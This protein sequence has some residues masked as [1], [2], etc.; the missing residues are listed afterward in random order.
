MSVPTT[1]EME[2]PSAVLYLCLSDVGR[3]HGGAA[4][5]GALHTLLPA[6]LSL[7]PVHSPPGPS[8]QAGR[9]AAETSQQPGLQSSAHTGLVCSTSHCTGTKCFMSGL[10]IGARARRHLF[11]ISCAYEC[12]HCSLKVIFTNVLSTA[13]FPGFMY[14]EGATSDASSTPWFKE[15]CNMSLV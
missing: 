4:A 6:L 1:R 9:Q 2:S 7:G 12:K 13:E 15:N 14:H 10:K 5:W 11:Y 3:E 8:S